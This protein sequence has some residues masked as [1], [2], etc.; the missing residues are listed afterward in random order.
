MSLSFSPFLENEAVSEGWGSETFFPICLD[1]E[2]IS[3]WHV[4]LSQ[5]LSHRQN[6]LSC[7]QLEQ[8][9]I[10]RVLHWCFGVGFL[11]L[12]TLEEKRRRKKKKLNSLEAVPE[13]D[14][15]RM[16]K[17]F[18]RFGF[19]SPFL[20]TKLNNRR[21]RERE[22]EMTKET[23]KKETW[24]ARCYPL[25]T[26]FTHFASPS[27]LLNQIFFRK[28][29]TTKTVLETTK[30]VRSQIDKKL[31]DNWHLML[32]RKRMLVTVKKGNFLQ[33]ILCQRKRKRNQRHSPFFR[34]H[35]CVSSSIFVPDLVKILEKM[36]PSL[37]HQWRSPQN[38]S[39][40]QC[41]LH[42]LPKS[43]PSACSWVWLP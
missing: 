2:R 26:F 25:K 42:I 16:Q 36:F 1:A 32:V 39:H 9:V 27:K 41:C 6:G 23:D 13:A 33:Y 5:F 24:K 11:L 4:F 31:F 43:N 20:D 12:G 14:K 7:R 30:T 38:D 28:K 17:P 15:F 35:C 10:L 19:T 34:L 37:S 18:V 8:F 29:W 22:R 21:T 3:H 40:T